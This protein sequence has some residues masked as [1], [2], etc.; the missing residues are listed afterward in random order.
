MK[1]FILRKELK[2]RTLRECDADDALEGGEF[3]D[4]IMRFEFGGQAA[5]EPD[6]AEDADGRGDGIQD[7][8]GGGFFGEFVAEWTH[9]GARDP[10]CDVEGRFDG[11]D[12]EDHDPG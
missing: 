9:D 1:P 6:D 12:L 8:E 10:D 7:G 4:D 11:E 3:V 2:H 5:G